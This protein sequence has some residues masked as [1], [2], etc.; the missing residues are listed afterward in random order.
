MHLFRLLSILVLTSTAAAIAIEFPDTGD[1]W[2]LS[3]GPITLKWSY[4]LGDP[5]TFRI[6]LARHAP[7]LYDEDIAFNVAT[8]DEQYTVEPREIPPNT[9]YQFEFFSN[10][11]SSNKVLTRSWSFSI[12]GEAPTTGVSILEF[13]WGLQ[14][15]LTLYYKSSTTAVSSPR[16]TGQTDTPP[17]TTSP[18]TNTRF[19]ISSSTSS[20]SSPTTS[21]SGGGTTGLSNTA[22]IVMAVAL[23][24]VVLAA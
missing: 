7:P 18:A 12:E 4:L 8:A 5:R 17:V 20:P 1:T 23:G 15:W 2:D 9:G 11:N 16:S 6:K 3:K 22:V 14:S 21:S 19:E 13:H 10:S 24:G